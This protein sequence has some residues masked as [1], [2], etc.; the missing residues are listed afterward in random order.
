MTTDN[1]RRLEAARTRDEAVRLLREMREALREATE[2][3][4]ENVQ[5]QEGSPL[6]ERWRRWFALTS[7]SPSREP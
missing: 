7:L 1:A 3:L 2:A 4:D 6:L 5:M